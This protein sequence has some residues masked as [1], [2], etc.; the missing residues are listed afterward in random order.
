M[1]CWFAD[2]EYYCT[3]ARQLL[4]S[5]A[6]WPVGG[7]LTLQLELWQAEGGWGSG[8]DDEP[9]VW[10]QLFKTPISLLLASYFPRS[11]KIVSSKKKPEL[12]RGTKGKTKLAQSI[13]G[14]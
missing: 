7:K 8:G 11:P 5:W 14:M 6:G 3:M 10:A 1:C 4:N 9:W 12:V 2:S 13:S